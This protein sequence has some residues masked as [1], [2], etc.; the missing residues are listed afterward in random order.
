MTILQV[1]KNGCQRPAVF[2]EIS[3]VSNWEL[4]SG[5]RLHN[6]WKFQFL[7]GKSTIPMAIFNSKLFV[8]QRVVKRTWDVGN[9]QFIH[10]F[11]HFLGNFDGW[12]QRDCQMFHRSVNISFGQQS[13]PSHTIPYWYII[14]NILSGWWFGT[15]FLWFSIILGMSSSQLTVMFFRGVETINRIYIYIRTYI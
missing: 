2:T 15:W 3:K 9:I 7:M 13:V 1:T 6:Y 14:Y 5:K 12:D 8:Y 4:P 10:C 11:A